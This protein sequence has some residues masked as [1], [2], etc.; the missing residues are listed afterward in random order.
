MTNYDN[1]KELQKYDEHLDT[2]KL[3]EIKQE[4]NR[5]YILGYDSKLKLERRTLPTTISNKERLISLFKRFVP[6]DW[7]KITKEDME[8]V[9]SELNNSDYAEKTKSNYKKMF[10]QF[11]KWFNGGRVPS[12]RTDWFST[13]PIK[14]KLNTLE[15][16]DLL[17]DDEKKKLIKATDNKRDTALISIW[18]ETGLRPKELRV[19]TV[20][21][22]TVEKELAY[23]N[24]PQD[25]K[26]GSRL[27]PIYFSKPYLI[28]Y[29]NEHPDRE[30]DKSPLW[31]KLKTNNGDGYKSKV[32]GLG[33]YGYDE[34]LIKIKQRSG[35]KK[36]I[37]WYLG[38]HNSYTD[39]VANGWN[40]GI[41]KQFHG[42]EAG[43]TVLNRYVHLSGK[44]V[45]A[46]VKEYY[47]LEKSKINAPEL[48]LK[49]CLNCA[50]ENPT[51]NKRCSKC[52]YIIDEK[53]M[54][55][56]LEKRSK[57]DVIKDK[58]MAELKK[59]MARVLAMLENKDTIQKARDI[60]KAKK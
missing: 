44:D 15:R 24:V 43:S 12:E 39:K 8:K 11:D 46:K 5:K 30:N 57:V 6:K 4:S 3:L 2:K 32:E 59:D 28:D 47:G 37:Y 9:I 31:V 27:I 26:T 36:R 14:R 41:L 10:K 58:E 25:T 38:R 48:T 20:G 1:I 53:T 18:L 60:K 54:A 35:I 40:E 42:I 33:K 49:K 13:T 55:E 17:T 45:T 52:G 19:L 56:E 50:R 7:A 16:N 23:I 34:I 22:V 29:L 51:T 21:S